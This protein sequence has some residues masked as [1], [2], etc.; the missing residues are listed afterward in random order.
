MDSFNKHWHLL[1]TG[2]TAVVKEDKNPALML[3]AVQ[4]RRKYTIA[5][6]EQ[7]DVIHSAR[8]VGSA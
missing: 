3:L 4:L 7:S 8:V 2:D 6:N 5:G 1:S